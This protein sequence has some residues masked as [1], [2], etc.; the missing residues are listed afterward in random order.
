M[1]NACSPGSTVPMQALAE[2]THRHGWRRAQSA[3]DSKCLLSNVYFA[4]KHLIRDLTLQDLAGSFRI[5]RVA[6]MQPQLEREQGSGPEAQAFEAPPAGYT[7][8]SQSQSPSS[9]LDAL[10]ST[11]CQK[12]EADPA[13]LFRVSYRPRTNFDREQSRRGSNINREA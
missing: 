7:S 6:K 8:H 1:F 10:W 9:T 3:S 12:E 2:C 13:S 11:F 4:V 5:K